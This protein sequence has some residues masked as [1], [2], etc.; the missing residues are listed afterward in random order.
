MDRVI[1][2]SDLNG[3]YASVECFYHPEIRDKPVAVG[4]DAEKRHGIILAK[5]EIAKSYGIKTGE[6]IWQALQK[7]PKL[8]CVKPNFQ[9]YLEYSRLVRQIYAEY[10]DK[11]EPFGL[12]E[13][14]LD[15]TS[16]ARLFG[17]GEKIAGELRRKVCEQ[18][19]VTVSVG[20]SW[21]KIFAKLGSDIKKPDATT[22]ISRENYKE[23]AW[24]RP[25]GDLLY[26]GR[27]TNRKLL[28]FGIRTIG[29]L[30]Q[31]APEFLGRALGK[32]GRM[33]W[34]FA[35]GLDQAPV[36]GMGREPLV[37]SV[38]NSTTAPR[39]LAD[40]GEVRLTLYILC[41]S[42]ASRL[43]EHSALARTVQVSFRDRDL[44]VYQR[45]APLPC[46]TSLSDSLFRA[47]IALYEENHLHGKP[48][49]S[50]GVRACSLQ[51]GE[52]LQLSFLE[53]QKALRRKEDLEKAVDGL[54][55]RFGHSSVMRA[56]MLLDPQ[57]S[58][59]NP[60]AEHTIHPVSYFA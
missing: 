41:E 59:V 24:A 9:R 13:C 10:T 2:H 58:K 6:A 39:D 47:A 60:K 7:C 43:R 14:W 33:L 17:D 52:N 20:V 28:N 23:V 46:P 21:N 4:G 54:R 8:V 15:V 19:G 35:N 5:N 26:V 30:A 49:R 32:N 45:Q 40:E 36:A 12:D 37:K 50:I 42:V 56:I 25:I 16:Q 57:L 1:L 31:S 11:V 29:E 22:V 3:F 53:S 18:L 51:S 48:L 44:F 55:E 27:S 38:G 34:V